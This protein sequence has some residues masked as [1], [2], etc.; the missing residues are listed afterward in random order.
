MGDAGRVN[1]KG[2]RPSGYDGNALTIE[3]IRIANSSEGLPPRQTDLV[4]Q[5]LQW[6]ENTWGKQPVESS[7]KA[8]VSPI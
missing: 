1:S 4:E 2:G 6:R 3:I 7:V 5:R 8:R